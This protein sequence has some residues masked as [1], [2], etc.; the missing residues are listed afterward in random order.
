MLYQRVEICSLALQQHKKTGMGKGEKEESITVLRS[1]LKKNSS[2]LNSVKKGR[3]LGSRHLIRYYLGGFCQIILKMPNWRIRIAR[4]L[5]NTD[6][7]QT[8]TCSSTN[9]SIYWLFFA[10]FDGYKGTAEEK[11]ASKIGF[12]FNWI[13][14]LGDLTVLH[15]SIERSDE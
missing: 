8:R 4:T 6:V 13:K 14:S 5:L 15:Y 12:E 10:W 7:W 3:S 11:I 1:A 2:T 9:L